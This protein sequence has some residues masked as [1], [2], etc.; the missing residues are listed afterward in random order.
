[1]TEKF[2]ITVFTPT[3]NRAL[4]LPSLYDSLTRQTN[5]EFIWLIV[6][7]GST[8]NTSCLINNWEMQGIIYIRYIFQDNAGKM[9]A[10]NKGVREC[11]TELFMCLD[12]DDYLSD[13]CIEKINTHWMKYRANLHISGMVAYRK[14]IGRTPYFFPNTELSTLHNLYKYYIGETALVFRT[15]ILFEH[16]F[17]EFD[18]EKFIGES[19]VL[20]K[21]DQKYLLAVIPE[22]WMIC[23]YRNDGYTIN[24]KNILI[25]NPK[26]WAMNAKQQ[27]ELYG[28]SLKKK[29]RYIS[30]Y[31]CASLFTRKKLINIIEMSPNKVLCVIC[32]P[33]GWMQKIYNQ[34]M[35]KK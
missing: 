17:P 13:D 10:Y 24:M 30:T 18:G 7:D 26:G 16:P 25:N 6:D 22:Y 11:Q 34:I 14:M 4:L 35:A 20:D 9:K 12:S 3:Y 31:I 32:L 27:Y 2:L 33:I 19:I 15:K 23:E 8:D 1:M 29:I 21:L 5:K 28:D